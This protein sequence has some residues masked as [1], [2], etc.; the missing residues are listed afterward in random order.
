MND[1]DK[2]IIEEVIET[3]AEAARRDGYAK[4]EPDG[5]GPISEREALE[6]INKIRNSIVGLQNIN[7]SEHIYPLVSL[8]NRAGLEGLDYPEAKANYGTCLEQR[9]EAVALLKEI[10]GG[11]NQKS[12]TVLKIRAL[13]KRI[14]P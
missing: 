6:G 14:D 5:K 3:T 1:D 2:A 12:E 10:T 11:W 13:L 4:F 9:N 8:L 7:W